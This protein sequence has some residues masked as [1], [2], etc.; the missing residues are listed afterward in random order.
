[1]VQRIALVAS[2]LNS[3][4][5]QRAYTFFKLLRDDFRVHITGYSKNGA[6][7]GP[8][9][10]D[11]SI[12]WRPLEFHNALGPR[13]MG[14]KRLREALDADLVIAHKAVNTS[15]GLGL[16]ARRALGVPL[17]LDVEE[18]E[19][20]LLGESIWWE[21]RRAPLDWCVAA[22]SPLYTR[23]L[24]RVIHS[25]DAITVTNSFLQ[26]RYGGT[27]VPHCRDE[28]VFRPAVRSAGTRPR[29]VL[30]LGTI[31][32]HKGLDVLIEAWKHLR[33]PDATLRIVGTPLEDPQVSAL[34]AKA[35]PS[36]VFE[37]HVAHEQVPSILRQA[38]LFVVPQLAGR[39]SDGQLPTKLIDAMATGL[40]IVASA[41]GDIPAWL[42][43][44]CG[45]LVEAGNP[46]AL[47]D[48]MRELLTDRARALSLGQAARERFMRDASFAAIRPRLIPLV[49]SLIAGRTPRK[50]RRS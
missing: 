18:W 25:A 16:R 29:T 43:N 39:G 32:P 26:G 9:S 8:L 31:R 42:S 14:R 37:G 28:T 36:I 38:D 24:D 12:D 13:V 17:L 23:L 47:A 34:R 11:R 48:A 44:G 27:L 46:E 45:V 21:M 22:D 2:D 30:F 3:N 1:M 40:P 6:I 4:S 41:I 19:I 35:D 33:V 15:F 50:A 10:H 49:S 20:G 5:L 7:W